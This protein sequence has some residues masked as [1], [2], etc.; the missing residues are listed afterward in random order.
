MP[1]LY[2]DLKFYRGNSLRDGWILTDQG[3]VRSVMEGPIPPLETERVSLGGA[4]VRPAFCD[5]HCHVIPSGLD[6]LRLNLAGIHSRS[7]MLDAI[8]DAVREVPAGEWLRAVQYDQNGFPDQAHLTVEELDSVSTEVPILLRH[9]S[10]H[11]SVANSLVLKAAGFS[12]SDPADPE[13]YRSADGRLSGLL[14]EGAHEKATNAAPKPS[15][16]ALTEAVERSAASMNAYGITAACEMMLG[17]IDAHRELDAYLAAWERGTALEVSLWVQYDSVYHH[18]EGSALIERLKGLPVGRGVVFGGIK[19]FSDGAISAATAAL[20]EPYASTGERGLLIY[21]PEELKRRV[22][23]ATGDGFSVAIHAIGDRAADVTMDAFEAS[24]NPERHR[25]EHAMLLDDDQIQRLSRLGCG[26]TI[27]PEFLARFGEAYRNQLGADRAAKLHRYGSLHRAGVALALS[28]D[29]PIVSGD[30]QIGLEAAIKRP[31]GFDPA[32]ALDAS[33]AW[34]GYTGNA[35]TMA[36]LNDAVTTP[37]IVA[38][39][40]VN[41]QLSNGGV[42]WGE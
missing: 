10:G 26:V 32:E 35:R 31:A 12:A 13:V 1:K 27:Q 29:R 34:A 15:S 21:Q 41:W 36:R 4:T 20:R 2:H 22:A 33:V 24:G 18:P 42:V 28:S 3:V 14:L 30:P 25:L 8:R 9:R 16:T 38:G 39:T 6:L 19:L 37:E 23:Q 11:A 40:R 7:A 17:C 5:A